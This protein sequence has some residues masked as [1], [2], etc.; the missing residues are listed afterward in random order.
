[1][2][3]LSTLPRNCVIRV[4]A[5][6]DYVTPDSAAEGVA[7]ASGWVDSLTSTRIEESRN[8]VEPVYEV[9]AYEYRAPLNGIPA[10]E[11]LASLIES[12]GAYETERDGSMLRA[13]DGV[14]WDYT[15]PGEYLYTLHA[16]VKH[17]TA[18][19]GWVE[20]DLSIISA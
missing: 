20:S 6:A 5:T 11:E 8:Y 1:M 7:E 18:T 10:R 9:D 15:Q 17:Y 12:L 14:T 16:H 4:Y 2:F 3:T 13:V 19:N